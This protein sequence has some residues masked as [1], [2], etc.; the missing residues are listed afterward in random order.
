MLCK[1]RVGYVM[2]LTSRT[3]GKGS[4]C[5]SGASGRLLRL[6]STSKAPS[7]QE[8]SKFASSSGAQIHLH[9]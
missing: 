5:E 1:Y 7:L 6:L 2:S 4:P 8:Y 3:L 9:L